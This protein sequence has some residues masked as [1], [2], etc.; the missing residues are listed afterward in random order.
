MQRWLVNVIVLVSG[1]SVSIFTPPL[2]IGRKT[3]ATKTYVR[4]PIAPGASIKDSDMSTGYPSHL[5][6]NARRMRPCATYKNEV[7]LSVGARFQ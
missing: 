2:D 4:I 1:P 5:L 7:S 3:E 6:M